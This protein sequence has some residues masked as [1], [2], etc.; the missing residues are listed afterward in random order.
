[1]SHKLYGFSHSS[2]PVITQY[3]EEILNAILAYDTDL[4]IE[5][6]TE[7]HAILLKF[8]TSSDRFPCFMLL[9]ND[10]CKNYIHSKM[11]VEQAVNWYKSKR[12]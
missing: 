9:K 8:S 11:S 6:G 5:Q 4:E 2:N 10:V 12:G 1:M 7:D 3:V